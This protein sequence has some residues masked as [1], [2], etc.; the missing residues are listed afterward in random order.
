MRFFLNIL[1]WQRVK[2]VKFIVKPHSTILN[3][4]FNSINDK[5]AGDCLMKIVVLCGTTQRV[6]IVV[7]STT[8]YIAY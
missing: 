3:V 4:R 6:G 8:D 5:L 1:A 2:N 7:P